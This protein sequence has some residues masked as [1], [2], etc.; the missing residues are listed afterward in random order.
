MARRVAVVTKISLE[1]LVE[2]FEVMAEPEAMCR[3]LVAR[4][5]GGD[6][7]ENRCIRPA[8]EREAK[9]ADALL[10]AR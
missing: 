7:N 5:E 3:R 6:R 1:K 4:R 2:M 9:L 8:A 10:L